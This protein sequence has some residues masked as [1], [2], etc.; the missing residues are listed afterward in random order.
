MR[1]INPTRPLDHRARQNPRLAQQLQ[2][3]A[4]SD[5]IDDRIH[6]ADLVE[7]HLFRRHSVNLAL[8]RGEALED[9]HR[10]LLHPIGELACRDELPDLSKVAAMFVRVGMAMRVRV[11]VRVRVRLG[12]VVMLAGQVHIELHPFQTRSASAR[13]VQVITLDPQLQQLLL[14]LAGIDPQVDQGGDE[15]VAADTAAEVEV[16]GLH[17]N[18]LKSYKSYMVTWLH[19]SPIV[20]YWHCVTM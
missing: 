5:N 15:H 8:Y 2:P 12:L 20:G 13:D 9:R 11:V 19:E 17:C 16:E 10:F 14:Q 4:G 1:A 6:R 3:D 18:W 7:A